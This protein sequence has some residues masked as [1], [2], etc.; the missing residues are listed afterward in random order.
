[1]GTGS[2]II[3]RTYQD[4]YKTGHRFIDTYNTYAVLYQCYDGYVE[5]GVCE[6]ICTFLSAFPMG[7]PGHLFSNLISY[8]VKNSSYAV[9][10]DPNNYLHL[11]ESYNYYVD[12]EESTNEVTLTVEHNNVELYSGSPELSKILASEAYIDYFKE[13]DE[14]EC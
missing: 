6:S 13:D 11:K 5:N 10:Y 1:M 8:F 2:L 9:L 7:F 4:R 12:I 3:M 14:D